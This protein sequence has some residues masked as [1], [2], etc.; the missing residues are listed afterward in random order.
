MIVVDSFLPLNIPARPGLP[1]KSVDSV[2]I[3]WIGPYPAQDVMA[4]INWWISAK[5]QASAHY[6]IKEDKVV[7]C[8]PVDEV[9]WH[10]GSSGNYTSIGIEV[11]P[12]NILGEFSDETKASLKKLINTKFKGLPLKRHYDWTGKNC[13][14]YYTPLAA[15]GLGNMRWE[16]LKEYING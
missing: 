8:V 14:L 6:V 4:P 5:I 3:H 2:T 11:V 7:N 10:C 1:M 13:P 15:D 16:E 9:A 12:K